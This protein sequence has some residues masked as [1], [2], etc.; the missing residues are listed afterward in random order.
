MA[1]LAR[2]VVRLEAD[3]LK[4][5]KELD[6]AKAK[7]SSFDKTAKATGAGIKKAFA[8]LAA[9]GVVAGMAAAAK[10]AIDLADSTSKAAA[11]IGTTTE[12]LSQLRYAAGLAGVS[13]DGLDKSLLKLNRSLAEAA[14]NSGSRVAKAF[15]ALGT[16][17]TDSR[18]GVKDADTALEDLADRF[19]G[20]QDG[21]A[22]T[23][24][25]MDIFGKSGA[26]LIPLLNNGAQAIRGYRKEADALGL[27][28][29]QNA[30]RAAEQ[31]NDNL[32]RLQTVMSGAMLQAA[33]ELT[34]ALADITNAMAELVKDGSAMRTVGAALAGTFKVLITAGLAVGTTFANLGR[35]I[36]GLAAAAAAVA[37]GE[38]RQAGAIIDAFTADNKAATASTEKAIH[39]LWAGAAADSSAGMGTVRVAAG[40]AGAAMI[41]MGEDAKRSAGAQQQALQQLEGMAQ[42]LTQ[43]VETLGMAEGAVLRYRLAQGD[44]AATLQQAGAAG[45]QYVQTILAMSDALEQQKML[46]EQTDLAEQAYLADLARGAQILESV[47]TPA[48]EYAATVAEL[49]RLLRNGAIAQETYNRAVA[50]AGEGMAETMGSSAIQ[51]EDIA[52]NMAQNMQGALSDFLFDPFKDGTDGML[53]AFS[54]ILRRM[55]AE[56]ASAS[57]MQQL[58]GI[59]GGPGGGGGGG[60]LVQAGLSA[61]GGFFGARANGGPVNAGQPYLVGERGPEL[62]VPNANSQVVNARETAGMGGAS[63]N[64]TVVTPDADS[65]RRS[66]RQ[67]THTLRR[68]LTA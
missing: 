30:A 15:A 27:T 7:L 53:D 60:G 12:A 47:R 21:A 45:Q 51:L 36:G 58:F 66:G 13:S 49:D 28:I 65:F 40:E 3:S 33:Q 39:D 67:V 50:E 54:N 56:A 26:D 14:T 62:V 22:K 1:D 55:A 52:K 59:G 31:F 42:Q 34:P 32:T 9:T 20:M 48:E 19:A 29:G 24:L 68:G 17:A 37:S 41:R 44:L 6:A 4:L 2:L 64:M 61:L 16:A 23:A 25:A 5:Q 38:F 43:Q 8:A 10:S 11:K 18:G 46:T 57:I 63:V 35:A